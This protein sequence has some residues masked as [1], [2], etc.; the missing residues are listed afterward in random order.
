VGIDDIDIIT[1]GSIDKLSSIKN[2]NQKGYVI[3]KITKERLSEITPMIL[4][5]NQG[6]NNYKE[7][8]AELEKIGGNMDMV[9]NYYDKSTTAREI[10]TM[11][12]GNE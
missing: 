1:N 10:A 11:Y 12:R 4:I 3:N 6:S 7:R 8:L 9:V 5:I 2:P